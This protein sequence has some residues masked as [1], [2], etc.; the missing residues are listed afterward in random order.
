MTIP[1]KDE[2]GGCN[3]CPVKL[4]MLDEAPFFIKQFNVRQS[5]VHTLQNECIFMGSISLQLSSTSDT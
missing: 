5:T 4:E 1:L 3:F 2:V